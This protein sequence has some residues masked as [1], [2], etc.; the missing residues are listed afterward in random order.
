MSEHLE[1]LAF[2]GLGGVFRWHEIFAANARL[3]DPQIGERDGARRFLQRL[4]GPMPRIGF[5]AIGDL[6]VGR[7]GVGFHLLRCDVAGYDDDGI[8]RAVKAPIK[9]Q[10]I[11][12]AELFDL[13]TPT[14]HRPPIGVV[15]V[16]RRIHLLAKPRR[17]IIGDPHILFFEHDIELGADDIVVAKFIRGLPSRGRAGS[18]RRS[19][20]SPGAR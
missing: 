17:G 16:E 11:V 2:A 9:S 19:S 4:H 10:R 12:A 20:P 15:E 14:D 1:R 6:G 18:R 13:R 7:F 5:G 3:L 8:V